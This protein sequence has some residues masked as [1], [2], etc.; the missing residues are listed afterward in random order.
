MKTRVNMQIIVSVTTWEWYVDSGSYSCRQKF[1]E[2]KYKYEWNYR[3][4]NENINENDTVNANVNG[5]IFV[6]KSE[7]ENM[8]ENQNAKRKIYRKVVIIYRCMRRI[9]QCYRC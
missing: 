1:T 2:R 4:R 7:N 3:W 5:Y 9:W 6:N 8:N